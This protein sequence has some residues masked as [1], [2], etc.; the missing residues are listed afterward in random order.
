MRLALPFVLSR[1]TTTRQSGRLMAFFASSRLW[2]LVKAQ[3]TDDR[4]CLEELITIGP[5]G[6]H[7]L[8]KPELDCRM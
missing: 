3:L 6:R 4:R 2:E 7:D 5:L 1:F 8:G